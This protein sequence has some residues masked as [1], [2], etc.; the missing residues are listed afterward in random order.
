MRDEIIEKDGFDYLKVFL[1]PGEEVYSQPGALVLLN[2]EVDIETKSFGGILKGLKRKIFGGESFFL[3]KFKAKSESELWF[4]PSL[5]GAL[6]SLELRNDEFFL[7]DGAYLS[8]YGALE[9]DTKFFGV[10]GVF[11]LSGLFWLKVS[12]FGKVFM[13]VFGG[14]EE[15][16]LNGEEILVDNYNLLVFSSSLNT[17]IVKIGG[18]KTFLFG[19]EGFMFKLSGYGKVLVQTRNLPSFAHEISRFSKKKGT[20][21]GNLFGV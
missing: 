2:G 4:S 20:T 19:G 12:G 7:R 8:H 14:V 9:I 13:N 11:S 5:P 3:N 1:N 6:K 18:M 16:E 10:K 15:I 21:I 17:E